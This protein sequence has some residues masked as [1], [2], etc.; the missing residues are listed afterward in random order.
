MFVKKEAWDEKILELIE[1]RAENKK[2]IQEL[3]ELRHNYEMLRSCDGY[4]GDEIKTAPL[5]VADRLINA[6]YM[7]KPSGLERVFNGSEDIPTV[8]L[9]PNELKEIANHLLV[10]CESVD[11]QGYK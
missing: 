6:H 10:Y 1:T 4:C 5:A 7:R 11:D 9:D 2:L 3:N 8:C